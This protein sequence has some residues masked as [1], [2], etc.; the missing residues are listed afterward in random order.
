MK[1][2]ERVLLFKIFYEWKRNR[3]KKKEAKKLKE[4]MER[5]RTLL[6][7]IFYEKSRKRK[8]KEGDV[9][10]KEENLTVS[11]TEDEEAEVKEENKKKDLVCLSSTCAAT[12]VASSCWANAFDICLV[13]RSAALIPQLMGIK[14]TVKG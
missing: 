10:I 6:F 2:K 12:A 1:E 14:L 9:I 8:R 5:K 7:K 3:K 13:W 4:N 11:T